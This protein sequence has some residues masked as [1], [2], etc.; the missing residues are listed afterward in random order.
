MKQLSITVRAFAVLL[1]AAPQAAI[2]QELASL[3]AGEPIRLRVDSP[4]VQQIEGRLV[5]L[6]PSI[7]V[8][9][10]R[11]SVR[12]VGISTI[13]SLDVKR[14][15]GRLFMKSV[16]IGL[17]AGLAGGAVIGYSTGDPNALEGFNA[18]GAA[19]ILGF[20]GAVAGAGAGAVYGACCAY[21]W[22]PVPLRQLPSL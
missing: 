17:L 10:E 1:L 15:N 12:P 20:Y 9:Q 6:S 13:R 5:S 19:L 7:L 14:R 22:K 4:S 18:T 21:S 2:G 8:L 11:G 16:G 3:R